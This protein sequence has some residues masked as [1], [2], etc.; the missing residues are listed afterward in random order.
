M[1]IEWLRKE[2]A[3]EI[4]RLEREVK[5]LRSRLANDPV[6]RVLELDTGIWL[7]RIEGSEGVWEINLHRDLPAVDFLRDMET[8][9]VFSGTGSTPAAAARAA[10]A[11]L[12]DQPEPKYPPLNP[13]AKA[14][15]DPNAY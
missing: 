11:A 15:K 10:L 9:E 3:Q 6:R 1:D 4:N 7:I 8:E 13:W 2:L 14:P 5:D 12:E